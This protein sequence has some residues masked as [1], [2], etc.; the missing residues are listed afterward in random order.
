MALSGFSTL[1]LLNELKNRVRCGEK[2]TRTRSILIGPP[3]E[4]LYL[5]A[6]ESKSRYPVCGVIIVG[7]SRC[8]YI[9]TIPSK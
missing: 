4:L 8:R 5:L 9:Y 6:P 3:G 2:T 7:L 1:A